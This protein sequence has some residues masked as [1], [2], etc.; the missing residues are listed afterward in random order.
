MMV[1]PC[2]LGEICRSS[3]QMMAGQAA[4]K[5]LQAGFSISPDRIDL[6]ADARRLKQIVINLLSNAVKFTPQGGSFGIEV[7]GSV[8]EQQVSLTVW[9]TGIGISAQ[10]Q[11][12]LFQSF[13]Q[14]DAR[15]SRQYQGTGLGLALV[16]RLAELHG[17]SV[18][19]QSE[20]GQGSRFTVTLPW[21]E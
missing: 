15:L 2:S 5:N 16:R 12:R 17:G 9:D 18:A 10:D 21:K 6:N 19:V 3:L 20:P 4:D 8:I 14:L 7:R 11:P 1:A 13:I